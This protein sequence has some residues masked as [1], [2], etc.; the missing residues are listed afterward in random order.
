LTNTLEEPPIK[1]AEA[2]WGLRILSEEASAASIVKRD[3]PIM[4]IAGNPPYSNFGMMNRGNF[5]LKLLNDYKKD[6]NEKK[7]NLD[8]DFIKFIR[9]AQWRIEQTGYGILAFITNNTYIDG[10]THRQM[11]ESLMN[12]FSEIFIVN[13][14]GNSNK[15]E[16]LLMEFQMKMYLISSKE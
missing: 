4:V 8:D 3:L 5:I 13:L 9:W 14:H 12:M 15:Q 2:L 1:I 7:L 16:K 6:L 10:I 11:R